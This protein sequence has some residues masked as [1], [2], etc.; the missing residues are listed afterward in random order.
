MNQLVYLLVRK[1]KHYL[2]TK[3][4]FTYTYFRYYNIQAIV[5]DRVAWSVCRCVTSISRKMA[6]PIEIPFGLWT[7]LDQRYH[8]SDGRPDPQYNGQF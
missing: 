4:Q 6:E 8:I 7:W 2:Q 5:R 1:I 3:A